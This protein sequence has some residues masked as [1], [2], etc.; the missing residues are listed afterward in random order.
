MNDCS[1]PTQPSMKQ[2]AANGVRAIVLPGVDLQEIYISGIP[3]DQ[4]LASAAE[5]T[6]GLYETIAELLADR[7]AAVVQERVYGALEA[8]A[9]IAPTRG[10]VVS[11]GSSFDVVPPTYIEGSPCG[12]DG[13]AGVHICAVA[14]ESGASL[15][16]EI[17]E[18][19]G[20]PVGRLF[21]REEGRAIYLSGIAGTTRDEP[22]PPAE[23]AGRMFER[24]ASTLEAYGFP[25]RDVVRTWIYIGDIL[26]WYDDFN[27]VRTDA[28]TRFGLL[29][30]GDDYLPA[31]TGIQ[32]R[33]PGQIEC[34]MDLVAIGPSPGAEV[35]IGRL[36]NPLQNEAYSY[37]SA[38]ARAMEVVIGG[39]RTV[40]V[41]G[42]AS[43]DEVGDSIHLDDI[44]GQI[45]R[46]VE[47]IEALIGTRD[48]TLDDICQATVFLKHP[49]H[50]ERFRELC[51][52]T[53]FG[54]LGVC[55]VADVCRPE[56]LFEIDAV[57]GKRL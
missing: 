44:D 12:A 9:E 25:Y 4:S 15:G 1:R 35:T 21:E 26:A 19:E 3:A 54:E 53:R 6:R 46:T 55:M 29:G 31:S 48:L 40:Y 7:Q 41:S 33:P 28:Y 49:S 17:V 16:V 30:H 14:P 43:I 22:M 24:A 47:N 57:A 23:Q 38:F 36:H 52:G 11:G 2:A 34:V 8:E 5:Q 51:A 27:P 18:H 50:V 37:G 10:H 32:G 39:T 56:L 20:Q 13:L 45:N 42:T